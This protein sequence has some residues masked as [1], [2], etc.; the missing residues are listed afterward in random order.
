[1]AWMPDAPKVPDPQET[2]AAQGAAN[3]EA[4]EASAIIGNVNERNPYGSVT[5]NKL[6]QEMITGTDG[7][8]VPVSRYER[9]TALS[10]EQQKLYDLGTQTQT[11]LGQLGVSQSQ[12]LQGLLGTSLDTKGLPDWQ[13]YGKAPQQ[14]TSFGGYGQ[15]Q[16]GFGANGPIQ[17]TYGGQG[18][19]TNSVDLANTYGGNGPVQTSIGSGGTIASTY[20]GNNPMQMG[21]AGGGNIQTAIGSGGAMRQ[22][23]GPTDRKAIEQ[24]MLAR[25]RTQAGTDRAK[26]E[27]QLAARGLSPGS[28]QYSTVQDANNRQDVDAY[29]Q[30]YL[31]S[32]DESRAAQDAYN[33]VQ[34]QRFAQGQAQGQFANT[35]QLQ[36]FNQNVQQGQFANSAQ[37][38]AYQQAAERAAFGNQAQNQRFTQG[39]AQGS[40]ANLAQQ[41]QYDQARQRADFGNQA[42]LSEGNFQNAAQLQGYNQAQGRADFANEAQQQDYAQRFGAGTFANAAQQQ[43]YQQALAQ[44]NFGNAANQQNYINDKARTDAENA[45]RGQMMTERQ[46]LRNA[47]INEITALMSGSQVSVPQFQAYNSPSVAS[48]PI[49]QYIQDNYNAQSQN[50]QNNMSGLFGLA[51]AGLGLFSPVK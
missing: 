27:A 30:A 4:A 36:Q 1:M 24:A 2:A 7:K 31:A 48:V 38:Q 29:N 20:G 10:P 47:P 35:A 8:Q 22:D 34:S 3:R 25:Y 33:Q 13:A 26:E 11:N 32:G 49:G 37:Q 18:K 40:F 43:N 42:L 39:Q 14:Q 9:V 46:T 45:R 6:G 15:A 41:Q 16:T 28:Q 17:S 51:G 50:Y 44:A 23:A 19:M 5:Y 12:K 21:V